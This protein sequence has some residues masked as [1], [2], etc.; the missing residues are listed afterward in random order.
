MRD[1]IAWKAHAESNISTLSAEFRFA[2]LRGRGLFVALAARSR[3][4][5]RDVYALPAFRCSELALDLMALNTSSAKNLRK[6]L[7]LGLFWLAAMAQAQA[8]DLGP[9]ELVKNVT[10]EVLS[11]IRS[12]KSIQT[13]RST[14]VIELFETKVQQHFDFAHMAR[15]ALGRYWRTATAAQ[16]KEITEEFHRLL[17][18]VY[19]AALTQYSNQT[20]VFQPFA[21]KVGDTDVK[22]RTKVVQSGAKP[23]S[24]DYYLE[25]LPTGW[26]VYDIEVAGISLV[27]NYRDSFAEIVRRNGIDGLI[28]NLHTKNESGTTGN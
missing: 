1:H 10:E 22:V 2:F 9:D 4:F 19:S 24:L 18:R 8:P 6:C 11:V 16:Q 25:K 20:I 12:D 28:E 3:V 23:I 13:D 14:K 26:E 21:M 7:L 17:V 5:L 15:L 27:A